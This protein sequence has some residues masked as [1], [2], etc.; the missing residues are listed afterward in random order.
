[1]DSRKTS[2]EASDTEH[3]IWGAVEVEPLALSLTVRGVT[4]VLQE[5]LL[6]SGNLETI[7]T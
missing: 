3:S 1:M 6:P 7:T 2:W 4:L 5:S